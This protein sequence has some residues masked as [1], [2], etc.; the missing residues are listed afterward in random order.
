MINGM[1]G[2]RENENDLRRFM[3]IARDGSS[4][5]AAALLLNEEDKDKTEEKKELNTKKAAEIVERLAIAGDTLAILFDFF[6]FKGDDEAKSRKLQ[7]LRSAADL[8]YPPA[9]YYLGQM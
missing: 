4:E 2:M 3:M 8:E 6:D 5:L 9:V 7:R 1:G